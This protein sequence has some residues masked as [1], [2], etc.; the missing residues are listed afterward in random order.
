[1][2]LADRFV[3]IGTSDVVYP[4]VGF[5]DLAALW[6]PALWNPDRRIPSGRNRNAVALYRAS[7][8][9]VSTSGF[10]LGRP[11]AIEIQGTARQLKSDPHPAFGHLLPGR[12]KGR[13]RNGHAWCEA[14][15]A[16]LTAHKKTGS[17]REKRHPC[18][19]AIHG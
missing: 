5:T 19:K 7:I 13:V 15:A 16:Q 4:A 14:W 18:H 10:S 12:E 9:P 17:K 3:A 8:W 1:V 6:N 11:F 2:L